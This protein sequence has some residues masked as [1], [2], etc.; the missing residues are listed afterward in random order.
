MLK[1]I[2]I[3]LNNATYKSKLKVLIYE[4]ELRKYISSGDLHFFNTPVTLTFKERERHMANLQKMLSEDNHVEIRLIDGQFIEDIPTDN[5]SFYL[6]KNLKFIKV[7]PVSGKNDYSIL[8]ERRIKKLSDSLFEQLWNY[9]GDLILIDKDDIL[10][11]LL[12]NTFFS[13]FYLC[14]FIY[15]LSG[16]FLLSISFF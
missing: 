3:F 16:Y 8:R 5:P 10:D 15:L 7:H 1:K 13:F 2:N 9:A 11:S 6:S 12:T 14:H 4:S